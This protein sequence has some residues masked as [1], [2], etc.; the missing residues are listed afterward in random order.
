M[1]KVLLT[2][3]KYKTIFFPAELFNYILFRWNT[4]MFNY[5]KLYTINLTFKQF[6]L[7]KKFTDCKSK[8]L[9][10]K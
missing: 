7:L 3:S 6:Y 10:N 5:N 8:P 2:D 1:N 9:G 4:R